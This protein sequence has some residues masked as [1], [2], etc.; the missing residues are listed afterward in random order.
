MT[1]YVLSEHRIYARMRDA[2]RHI[3]KF[4]G[5]LSAAHYTFCL[6]FTCV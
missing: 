6:M 5:T 2:Y 3:H 1:L 4:V